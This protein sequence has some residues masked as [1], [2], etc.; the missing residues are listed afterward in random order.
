[1]RLRDGDRIVSPPLK[2]PYSTR[3]RRAPA[4]V[5]TTAKQTWRYRTGALY[6][7]IPFRLLAHDVRMRG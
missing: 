1:V 4:L 5:Q 7:H 6:S 2:R 3:R